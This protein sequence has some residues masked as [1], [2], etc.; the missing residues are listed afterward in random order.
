[1][2]GFFS[3][4][5]ACGRGIGDTGRLG[6]VFTEDGFTTGRVQHDFGFEGAFIAV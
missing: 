5:R 6:G 1:L 2:T 3:N 4:Q